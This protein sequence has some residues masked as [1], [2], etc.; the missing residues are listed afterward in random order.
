MLPFNLHCFAANN[1]K[2]LWAVK[3]VV[4]ACFSRVH[5]LKR[6]AGNLRAAFSRAA[7]KLCKPTAVTAKAPI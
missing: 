4:I 1:K 5:C 3:A 2:C 7:G 6:Q